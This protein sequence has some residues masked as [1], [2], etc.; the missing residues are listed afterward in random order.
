MRPRA[1]QQRGS[2]RRGLLAGLIFAIAFLVKEI[3]L[4]FAPVPFL[5][6]LLIGRPIASICRVAAAALLVALVG[7]AWWFAMYADFD[8]W[9]LK[10]PKITTDGRIRF[11]H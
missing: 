5:V 1:K 10:V 4:P 7:T 6:G 11:I 3:A 9:P 2:P 8:V